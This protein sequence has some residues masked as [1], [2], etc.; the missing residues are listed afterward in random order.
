ML[1]KQPAPPEVRHALDQPVSR[2]FEFEDYAP[3]CV[4]VDA[5]ASLTTHGLLP[6]LSVAWSKRLHHSLPRT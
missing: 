5:D 1:S 3:S 2:W 4:P 6:L